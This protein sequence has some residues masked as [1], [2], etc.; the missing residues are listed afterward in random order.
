[1]FKTDINGTEIFLEGAE[2]L[3]SPSHADNGTLHMISCVPIEELSK[4]SKILDLG[5]GLGLVGIYFGKL[6]PKAEIHM[7][8]L[9][10]LAVNT[11]ENNAK[12]NLEENINVKVYQSNSFE[13]ITSNDFDLILSN[14]PYHT[15]FSV[16]KSF[17]EGSFYHLKV[18]GKLLMVTKRLDWYKN[19]L[20][21]V[22]GGCKVITF[23]D[24]YFVFIAEKRS[25]KKPSKPQKNKNGL[26]KKLAR[27][28]KQ[29]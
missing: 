21:T 25:S 27:K 15:D 8:D 11:S 17:I 3:F 24:G 18:G 12:I 7:T 6:F 1:M 26:S 28:L 2:G 19:K 16:A 14:P 29:A 9:S 20:T 10:E 13:N 5:C 23:D 4:E 22:F